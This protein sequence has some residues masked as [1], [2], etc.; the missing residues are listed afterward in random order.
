MTLRI[1]VIALVKSAEHHHAVGLL[2]LR[3]GFGYQLVGSARVIEFLLGY[4]PVILAGG[5][6]Y[7]STGILHAYLVAQQAAHALKR[8]GLA[9]HL[10]R[11]AAAAYGHHL[12]RVL[13]HHEHTE[14]LRGVKRQHSAIVLEQNDTLA[15]Y[16]AGRSIVGLGVHRAETAVALHRGTVE[17]A[18]HTAHL[19]VKF[20]GGIFALTDELTVRT[21][22]VVIV[23]SVGS[24]EGEAVGPCPELHVEAVLDGLAGVVRTAPVAH[25]HAVKRPVA[26]QYVHKKVA[27]VAVV[28]VLV[29]VV[30]AHEGPCVAVLH[31]RLEGWKVYLVQRAVVNDGV[32]LV[33]VLLVV[34]Q[35]EVLYARADAVGLESDDVR[36]HHPRGEIRVFAHVLEVASAERGAQDVDARAKNHVFLA[37]AGLLAERHAVDERHPRVPRG[38]KTRQRGECHARVVSLSGLHPLVPKHV[39]TYAVR[40][41]VGPELGYAE[42]CHAGRAELAL[43]VDYGDFLVE[44]HAP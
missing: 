6:A 30:T 19:V 44:R 41:V 3:H 25:Y 5:I 42:T 4:H 10:Q 29:Q 31:G 1:L 38:G 18:Q 34:V 9:L 43:G 12:D 22:H 40:A 27:V 32:Y 26:L 15:G 36:H 33:A 14:R 35:C 7:V 39:G 16:A 28:L 8:K 20:L 21:R 17:E 11:R 2:G 13:A 23:V 37:V 24:A